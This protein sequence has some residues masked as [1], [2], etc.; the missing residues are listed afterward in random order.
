MFNSYSKR[1]TYSFQSQRT[2]PA[3][4][5]IACIFSTTI[6]DESFSWILNSNPLLDKAV[7]KV[8][9]LLCSRD[10]LM[11]GMHVLKISEGTYWVLS[12]HKSTEYQQQ[13]HQVNM[14]SSCYSSDTIPTS[15]NLKP[16]LTIRSIRKIAI[17]LNW[18]W[19]ASDC[20]FYWRSSCRP[21]AS[22]RRGI[23]DW[24]LPLRENLSQGFGTQYY[25]Y[26]ACELYLFINLIDS[27]NTPLEKLNYSRS[28]T[29]P[30]LKCPPPPL[31]WCPPPPKGRKCSQQ[32]CTTILTEGHHT[33][34]H[35][36]I[37]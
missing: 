10:G 33:Y 15:Q 16:L 37:F 26:F 32:K 4:V 22:H 6:F 35:N 21:I 34:C 18:M 20:K 19:Q 13:T 27:S 24:R 36:R 25:K 1:L 3:T 28:T 7:W 5:I 23:V 8:L 2:S 31:L 17:A 29:Y 14:I 12:T 9:R 11:F 30:K